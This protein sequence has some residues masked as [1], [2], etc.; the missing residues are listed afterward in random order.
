MIRNKT[1]ET[2]LCESHEVADS[3]WKKTRGLMFREALPGEHGLLMVFEPPSRP[4]IWM[5]GMRFPI[6]IVF[7]DPDR[8]VIR[9]VE[10]A[11]PLGLSWRT[12][13]IFFPPG[14]SSFV[15]ELPAGRASETRTLVG[16][17]LDF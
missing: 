2:V 10:N 16:N 1:K 4:G 6:D 12:W 14:P 9:I 17:E 5:L 11:R 8:R 3:P 15:L 13:R 7:L